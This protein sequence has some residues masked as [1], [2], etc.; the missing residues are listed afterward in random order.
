MALPLRVVTN[1]ADQAADSA[2]DAA[3]GTIVTP[4]TATI[5]QALGPFAGINDSVKKAITDAKKT[6]EEQKQLAQKTA[7]AADNTTKEVKKSNTLLGTMTGAVSNLTKSILG[8]R[9]AMEASDLSEKLDPEVFQG[10]AKDTALLAATTEGQAKDTE[11]IRDDGED[12]NEETKKSNT[13]LGKLFDAFK[14]VAKA[15]TG[16]A[17]VALLPGIIM[18]DRLQFQKDAAKAEKDA[19]KMGLIP[20]LQPTEKPPATKLQPTPMERPETVETSVTYKGQ[21]FKQI[22]DTEGNIIR[23]D[24]IVDAERQD[25]QGRVTAPV[26]MGPRRPDESKQEYLARL[27][28]A[29]QNRPLIR[30]DLAERQ[31]AFEPGQVAVPVPPQIET[32][33]PDAVKVRGPRTKKGP[34]A[35]PLQ[36]QSIREGLQE[37]GDMFA[38][39]PGRTT[40]DGARITEQPAER[41]VNRRAQRAAGEVTVETMMKPEIVNIQAPKQAAITVEQQALA[42]ANPPTQNIIVNNTNNT[43]NTQQNSPSIITGGKDKASVELN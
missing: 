10:Q 2:I 8:L 4:L 16:A 6:E 37:I 1:L 26:D 28:K 41:I 18:D 23:Q 40:F 12:N 31:A 43:N 38:P 34:S 20:A 33:T 14:G 9:E 39:A 35:Q 17:T 15:V 29:S 24:S 36:F 7:D 21:E 5:K 32:T 3:K 25:L 11:T 19:R 13:L 42:N 22:R 30:D 27:E